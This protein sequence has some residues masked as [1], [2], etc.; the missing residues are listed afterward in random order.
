[1]SGIDPT[2]PPEPADP[3]SAP[4]V[5]VGPAR[6][7][8]EGAL[9]ALLAALATLPALMPGAEA[10]FDNAP[11]LVETVALASA[12]GEAQW[13]TAWS[14]LAVGGFAV[15]Q[16]NAPLLWTPLAAAVALGA[17]AVPTYLLCIP[18]SNVLFALGAWRFARRLLSS[19]SASWLGAALAAC[20]PT[21][22]W[23]IGG[24][25]SGMWPWRLG[26]GLLL[27]GLA[28]N[29]ARPAVWRDAVWLAGATLA[30]TFCGVA[31][32]GW[33]LWRIAWDLGHRDRRAA[34]ARAA[35]AALALGLTAF[36]WMPLIDGRVREFIIITPWDLDWV[37]AQ[38]FTAANSYP[39]SEVLEAPWIGGPWGAAI[40][41][42][43]WVG[44]ALFARGRGLVADRGLALRAGVA[45][46][47]LSLVAGSCMILEVNAI[48]G[49]VPWRYFAFLHL[50]LAMSGGAGLMSVLPELG[51]A[52]LAA[53][54]AALAA[55]GG[56][57]EGVARTGERATLDA[58]LVEVWDA[59]A[60]LSPPGRIYH[61]DPAAD[62]EA[63]EALRDTHIGLL[64]TLRHGYPTLGSWYG[65]T[66]ITLHG[67]T[68][69]E[70]TY[71][72]GAKWSDLREH[73]D[74]FYQRCRMYGVGAVVTVTPRLRAYLAQDPRFTQVAERG[75]FGAF[76]VS[77]P[78]T[79]PLA[80][81]PESG[82]LTL[83]ESGRDR[84]VADVELSAPSAALRLRVGWHPWWQATLDGEPVPLQP[85]PTSGLVEGTLT[86]SGR[87][88][89]RWVNRTFGGGWVSL[90]ALLILGVGLGR[91][92]QRQRVLS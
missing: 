15:H 19:P 83:L 64:M 66:A 61:E 8:R 37:L 2:T 63:P 62:P 69:S 92:R 86:R 57:H 11:H 40:V 36:F 72:M 74:W 21:E 88:E 33:T 30:H 14:D 50:A 23:G 68:G 38:M 52:P 27:A 87:L 76:L 77:D 84:Y 78:V 65:V 60:E 31:G 9:L 75:A 48:L 10:Y 47:V 51:R 53:T 89:M 41:G 67:W 44:V 42:L 79:T 5:P 13:F 39:P 3:P 54:L 90:G 49:P 82:Q 32:F 70:H 12:L 28:R 59:L 80:I 26:I 17:P 34:G 45:L 81:P 22:L 71:V 6:P 46:A 85:G 18:L 7:W 16:L 24:A 4:P 25:A 43:T 20:W 55:L 1:M 35:G 58:E 29:D 73:P 91:A 56:L